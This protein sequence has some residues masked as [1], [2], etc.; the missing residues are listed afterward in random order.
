MTTRPR[1]S[2]R[3]HLAFMSATV[4]SGLSSM[5][6]FSPE[7]TAAALAMFT[8]SCSR[9]LPVTRRWFSTV[10]WLERMRVTSCSRDISSEKTAT[11]L[12]LER[13]TLSAMLSAILVLPIPGRAASSTRSDLLSPFVLSS[14]TLRPVG[15]PGSVLPP[16]ALSSLR[17]SRTPCSTTPMGVMFCAERPRRTA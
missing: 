3:R 1:S 16:E 4:S 6:M 9:R 15:R 12:P 11:D 14:S 10:A 5:R 7:S 2:I 8:Q 13:A 17:W